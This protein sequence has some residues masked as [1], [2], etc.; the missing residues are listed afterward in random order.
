[1]SNS[2]L[3]KVVWWRILGRFFSFV[4]WCRVIHLQRCLQILVH[5]HDRRQVSTPVTIV[6]RR[7]HIH[8]LVVEHPLVSLHHHLMRPTHQT[9]IV[10]AVELSHILSSLLPSSPHR[11]RRCIRNHEN[12]RANQSRLLQGPTTTSR[13]FLPPEESPALG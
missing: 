2:T 10:L 3:Q 12:S 8:Q 7:P 1:M 13:T 4:M 6:R 9:Q 11:R 5:F